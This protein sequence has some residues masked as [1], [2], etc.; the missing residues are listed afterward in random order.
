[1]TDQKLPFMPLTDQDL[2]RLMAYLAVPLAVQQMCDQ[3]QPLDDTRRYALSDMIA[4]QTPDRALMGL[5]LSAMILDARLRTYDVRIA[6][7]VSMSAEM[8]VQDYAPTFLHALTTGDI[9]TLFD[10]NVPEL[11]ATVPEDLE[12]L[13]D[14][15]AVVAGLVPDRL[16]L[17]R[18]LAT[19]L[20]VQAGAQALV[21]EVLVDALDDETIIT[22]GLTDD[23]TVSGTVAL[24]ADPDN[25]VPFRRR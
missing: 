14:L 19:L 3:D 13:A 15:L 12:S 20:S 11:L 16:P 8:M 21:A 5:A 7:V 4:A 1:M 24:Q 22:G 10:A 2:A 9:T 6:E 18:D 17:Y 25:I 23:L